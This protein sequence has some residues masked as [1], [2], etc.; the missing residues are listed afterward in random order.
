MPQTVTVL[1][2]KG[3]A[4]SLAWI[5]A[6]HGVAVHAG[7]DGRSR[8]VVSALRTL[9]SNEGRSWL[10]GLLGL[11]AR[12][13]NASLILFDAGGVTLDPAT[14]EA[15]VRAAR[16][17]RTEPC[18]APTR[19]AVASL[20][21]AHAGGSEKERIAWAYIEDG[22]LVVWSCEPRRYAV[23]VGEI[24]ALARLAKTAPDAVSDFAVTDSGSYMRW[25]V[26]DIDL[27][28][29]SVRMLADPVVRREYE[30]LARKDMALYADAIRTFRQECGLK[31]S[32]IDGMTAR[33]VRRLEGGAMVP[34]IGTLRKFAAA[35]RMTVGEY[36]HEL[37]WRS[38]RMVRRR[39]GV[40]AR[41]ARQ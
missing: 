34:Q 10:L 11:V 1:V 5:G 26:A 13:H 40:A 27:G 17:L 22:K 15:L 19:R 20:L 14:A 7:D 41:T 6:I 18:I 3:E 16:M 36:L 29:D 25:P 4:I 23:P 35:H 31:Q 38:K 8:L 39:A 9:A 33:T 28:L 37:A 21:S 2:P 32:D 30:S 24:T 12:R